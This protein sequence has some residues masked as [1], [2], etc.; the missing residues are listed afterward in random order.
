MF[1]NAKKLI[2]YIIVLGQVST[3]YADGST[4]ERRVD[5]IIM[6]QEA[7]TKSADLLLDILNEN[8]DTVG[9][10]WAKGLFK[11]TPSV[12]MTYDIKALS[13]IKEYEKHV[14][15]TQYG[16]SNSEDGNTLNIGLGYNHLITKNM[17]P[18]DIIV[19]GNVFFDAKA[20]TDSLFSVFSKGIHKRYSIG[21]TI[22]TAKA[23]AFFN[24]YRGITDEIAQYKTSDGY[25]FGVNGFSTG[26]R[27]YKFRRD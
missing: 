17:L 27:K 26:I 2:F 18:M 12:G 16:L 21:G 1:H 4:L 3:S 25:D 8:A 6:A 20:A 14:L 7:A 22:M 24:I 15:F 5:G 23:G 10:K 13:V 19:G 9:I 11:A